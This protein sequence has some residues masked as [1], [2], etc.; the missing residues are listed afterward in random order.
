MARAPEGASD[1]ENNIV[2]G[3]RV[4]DHAA[5][6]CTAAPGTCV[7]ALRAGAPPRVPKYLNSDLVATFTQ[8]VPRLRRKCRPVTM[9]YSPPG[10]GLRVY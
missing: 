6:A 2:Y 8:P 7:G 10:R 9:V 5:R 1:G 3:V 4:S